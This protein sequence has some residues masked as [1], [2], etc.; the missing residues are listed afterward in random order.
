MGESGILRMLNPWN[1]MSRYLVLIAFLSF[2]GFSFA[3]E[4]DYRVWM[5]EGWESVALSINDGV[6]DC[7]L[8][9]T[10]VFEIF[11]AEARRARIKI[12]KPQ[13][14][15]GLFLFTISCAGESAS[16]IDFKYF[17]MSLLELYR[18]ALSVQLSNNLS[19][20]RP[21]EDDLRRAVQNGL[22]LYLEKN[23]Q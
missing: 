4:P 14:T 15:D 11:E 22:D 1:Q 16:Y 23:L 13:E 10:R 5:K 6:V 17:P 19:N 3:D 12:V 8:S 9:K 18:E 20:T 7:S 2:N 21:S